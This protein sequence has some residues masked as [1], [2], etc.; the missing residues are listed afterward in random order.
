MHD[1]AHADMGNVRAQEDNRQPQ[2]NWG[3]HACTKP[4]RP[5]RPLTALQQPAYRLG[6]AYQRL[7]MSVFISATQPDPELC[8]LLGMFSGLEANKGYT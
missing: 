4:A 1:S 7:Y 5:P 6:L 2:K 8:E 3:W